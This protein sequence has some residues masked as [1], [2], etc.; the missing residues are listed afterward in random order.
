MYHYH[1][2]S[3]GLRIVLK[4]TQSPV[5]YSSVTIGV[6]SR[7]EEGPAEGLA[8]FIEHSLFKGTEHRRARHILSRIDGV[9]GELNAVT[10]KEETCIYATSLT[11]HLD[12]CL[13]LFADILFHSTFPE[14]EIIRERDVVIEEIDSYRDSP[15]ELIYD[16]YEELAFAGHPLAHNILGTKRN[17]RRFTPA[18]LRQRMHE[19]YTPSRMVV[20]VVGNV[21]MPALVRLCEKYFGPYPEES[22]SGT[23]HINLSGEPRELDERT[24][25]HINVST[26]PRINK[27]TYPQ[28][29][30]SPF[31]E[32]RSRHTHQTHL[33]LGCP[34]PGLHDQRRTA[35]TLLNNILGGPA[36]NSRLNVA[37]RE[38]YG[39]CYTIESQYTLFTDAGLFCIYAGVDRDSRQRTLQ[40]IEAELRRLATEPLTPAQLRQAQRQLIGQLTIAADNGLNEMQ[41]M[42]KACLVYGTVDT[43]DDTVRDILAL[44]SSQLHALAADLFAPSRL[45]T[46]V[47]E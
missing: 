37:V 26:Y 23:Q 24:Y 16:E 17:V 40:L 11:C 6:G 29:N 14:A 12:R 42:G 10:T 39:F 41:A 1:T 38:R 45:S 15:A 34:A 8:H 25:P 31:H 9:G 2:L 35:F 33:I 27:S 18:M 44:T 22:P 21:A 13:E 36:M 32:V 4:P 3:N 46:L 47:Y 19:L 7:H 43:L 20:S 5:T 28:L 30:I